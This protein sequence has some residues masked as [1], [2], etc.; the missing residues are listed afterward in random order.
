DAREPRRLSRRS[1]L[2]YQGLHQFGKQ[3]QV[4]ARL[5]RCTDLFWARP[6]PV[7]SQRRSVVQVKAERRL[8][9]YMSLAT[10]RGTVMG[11]KVGPQTMMG[12]REPI[13]SGKYD[14]GVF[15]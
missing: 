12:L 14:L 1:Q 15:K 3:T 4:H 10:A 13:C 5:G 9:Q 2:Q 6:G 7:R 11:C 8:Q